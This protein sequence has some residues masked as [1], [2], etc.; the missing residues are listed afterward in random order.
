MIKIS[1]QWVNACSCIAQ[2]LGPVNALHS[3]VKATVARWLL[4]DWLRCGNRRVGSN[5]ESDRASQD[6][7]R[8]YNVQR[9]CEE[10]PGA[11]RKSSRALQHYR[12]DLYTATTAATGAGRVLL[13]QLVRVRGLWLQLG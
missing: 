1:C 7:S 11:M 4:D 6:N 3:G 2:I 5:G 8:C 12:H 10:H 13:S 9:P